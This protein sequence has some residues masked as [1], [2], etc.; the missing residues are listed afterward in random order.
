MVD[1]AGTRS[2]RRAAPRTRGSPPGTSTAPSS[3]SAARAGVTGL[4]PERL[5]RAIELTRFP[6]PED[7]D[8]AETATEAGLVRAADLIG[9]LADPGYL[10]KL[11]A[12]FCEFPETGTAERLGY[13]SPADLVEGYPRFFWEQGE[14]YIG[15]GWPPGADR[16]GPAVDR[17]P[18]RARVRGRA[19]AAP[20]RHRAGVG[21]GGEL[22]VVAGGAEAAG[23]Q[24][25][26]R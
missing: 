14:P 18:V 2:R 13:G 4:D 8:H 26:R 9:Q 25:G 23:A 17:E 16:G 24:P 3:S 1:L 11:T 21:A 15:P 22:R 5:C 12:L 20:A 6:V 7:G 10:R 19:P